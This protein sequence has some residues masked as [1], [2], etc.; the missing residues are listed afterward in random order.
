MYFKVIKKYK[1]FRP[2]DVIKIEQGRAK[3]GNYIVIKTKKG[4][5][6]TKFNYFIRRNKIIGKVTAI[7]KDF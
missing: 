1:I 6:L 3:S 7:I 5:K 4:Y 2:G